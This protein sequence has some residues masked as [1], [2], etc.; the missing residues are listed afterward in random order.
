MIEN[1][2]RRRKSIASFCRVFCDYK[3][4][5]KGAQLKL[6]AAPRTDTVGF[7]D[8]LRRSAIQKFKF[9]VKRK[10]TGRIAL[11]RRAGLRYLGYSIQP[12]V[13]LMTCPV[14]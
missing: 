1:K 3:G 13:T 6:A 10:S 7:Q 9:K 11:L 8:E 12:P 14:M 2:Q 5:S 4:K